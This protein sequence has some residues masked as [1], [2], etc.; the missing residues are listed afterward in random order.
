MFG[1]VA[2]PIAATCK[3]KQFFWPLVVEH[4]YR[5]GL[6]HQLDAFIAHP[7]RLELLRREQMREI[8][9]AVVFD[10]LLQVG[11]V[12]ENPVLW[13]LSVYLPGVLS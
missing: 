11:R 13:V 10:P 5:I 9:F 6:D 3:A 7:A 12:N 2:P 4:Q 1:D 8:F